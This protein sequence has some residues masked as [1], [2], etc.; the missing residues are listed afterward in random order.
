MIDILGGADA[1]DI[2]TIRVA[3]LTDP[4]SLAE[5]ASRMPG[6]AFLL[7][8]FLVLAICEDRKLKTPEAARA[9]RKLLA[10]PCADPIDE[11]AATVLRRIQS[12]ALTFTPDTLDPAGRVTLRGGWTCA[13]WAPSS[14]GQAAKAARSYRENPGRR[15]AAW[16]AASQRDMVAALKGRYDG[17]RQLTA[18]EKIRAAVKAVVMTLMA[19]HADGLRDDDAATVAAVFLPPRSGGPSPEAFLPAAY[20]AVRELFDPD[21]G[22]AG[23]ITGAVTAARPTTT[24]RK[25]TR[26]AKTT[27][28]TAV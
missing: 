7:A 21:S 14:L 16:T 23:R 2:A 24:A 5:N 27:A 26:K 3:V 15:Y 10:A 17:Q 22:L 18:A 12:G 6:R 11:G 4:A 8:G 19:V 20:A 25:A 13:P 28:A 1:P 9:A